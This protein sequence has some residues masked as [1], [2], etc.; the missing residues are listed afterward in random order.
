MSNNPIP[1]NFELK[2]VLSPDPGFLDTGC[3][4]SSFWLF[5]VYFRICYFKTSFAMF[6]PMAL[7]LS[8]SLAQHIFPGPCHLYLAPVCWV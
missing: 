3:E 1:P 8:L 5:L 4:I 6:E 2:R 7:A